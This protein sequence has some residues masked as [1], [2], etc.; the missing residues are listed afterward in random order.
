MEYV[1]GASLKDLIK[2]GISVGEAVEIDPPGARRGEVRPRARD[3]PPRPQ[4]AERAR[5]PRGPRAGG[6]LRDRPRRGLG[7]HPDGLGA[8]HR[9]VPLARAGAGP[10]DHR[11]V[12]PLLGRGDA[13]RGAHRPGPVRGRDAGRRRAEAD[14]RAAPPARPS[15]TRRCARRSTRSFCGRWPRTRR[16]ASRARGRVPSWRS[17]P[18]R[19]TPAAVGSPRVVVRRGG[20]R[21][22]RRALAAPRRWVIALAVIALARAPGSPPSRSPAPPRSTCRS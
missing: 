13:L 14:L 4:A 1:E 10:R 12:G 15:S 21:R 16:I 18:P 8:G 22:T 5:R 19:P 7:D 9:P 2:R 20:R 6:G 11:D 17:T 3:H